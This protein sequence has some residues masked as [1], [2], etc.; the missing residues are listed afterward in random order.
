MLSA[1]ELALLDPALH[2]HYVQHRLSPDPQ[3]SGHGGGVWERSGPGPIAFIGN[4]WTNGVTLA[5]EFKVAGATRLVALSYAWNPVRLDAWAPQ[6][7]V[8]LIVTDAVNL[9]SYLLD[10][11]SAPS[12]AVIVPAE[13]DLSANCS[14]VFQ[15]KAGSRTGP[16]KKPPYIKNYAVTGRYRL[17]K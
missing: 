3:L 14:V 4:T 1:C 12:G 7:Q 6:C 11:T 5:P 2:D 17:L 15:L 8:R 16:L 9:K 13:A 10:V